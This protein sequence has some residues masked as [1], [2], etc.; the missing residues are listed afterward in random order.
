MRKS[1]ITL[2]NDLISGLSN[3]VTMFDCGMLPTPAIAETTPHT[4][5]DMGAAIMA[6][7]HPACDNGVKF[8]IQGEDNLLFLKKKNSCKY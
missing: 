4:Q 1:G 3:A 2:Q 8:L 7:H 6:S 5:S